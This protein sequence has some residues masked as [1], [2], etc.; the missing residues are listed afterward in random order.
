MYRIDV[1][2]I[3][4]VLLAT[5]AAFV[6]AVLPEQQLRTTELNVP[7]CLDDHCGYAGT[8]DLSTPALGNPFLETEPRVQYVTFDAATPWAEVIARMDALRSADPGIR[9]AI[10]S[11]DQEHNC[12]A[13]P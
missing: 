7:R 8:P 5:V 12:E 3:I 4:G 2:P 1:T 9:I 13:L 10:D 11:S 6:A